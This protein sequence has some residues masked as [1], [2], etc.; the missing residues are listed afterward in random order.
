MKSEGER[1]RERERAR[2]RERERTEPLG[3]LRMFSPWVVFQTRPVFQAFQRFSNWL[4]ADVPDI[5]EMNET[6]WPIRPFLNGDSIIGCRTYEQRISSCD[7][8]I[9]HTFLDMTCHSR[10]SPWG[11]RAL[12]AFSAFRST[13][14]AP[15]GEVCWA[16][17]VICVG[18]NDWRYTVLEMV[19]DWFG[20]L[21]NSIAGA[22]LTLL[23]P[24]SDCVLRAAALTR[25]EA[26][27]P[28]CFATGKEAEAFAVLPDC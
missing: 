11:A 1:E 28:V 13:D 7:T 27:C 10:G 17:C 16:H 23:V 22:T 3:Y 18:L 20:K 21:R 12:R 14:A 25:N 15:V 4:L 8:A 19:C 24:C 2:E 6:T 9:Y 26:H 5:H